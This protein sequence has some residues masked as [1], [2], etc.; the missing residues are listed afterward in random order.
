MSYDIHDALEDT[1]YELTLEDYYESY[2]DMFKAN[3]EATFL[4]ATIPDGLIVCPICEGKGKYVN[5]SI[6]SHGLSAE[7]FAEDPDFAEDYFRGTY[8]I[9]CKC[10]AGRNVVGK[11]RYAKYLALLADYREQMA[12]RG[13]RYGDSRL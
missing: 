7:D 1:E 12:E 13:E 4:N 11:L 2:P 10:C 6:D 8:D 5:P 9:V 3:V